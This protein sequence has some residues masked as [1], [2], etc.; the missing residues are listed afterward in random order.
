MKKF[1]L[2][3]ILFSL[4]LCSC[5]TKKEYTK[6]AVT[7]EFP[8]EVFIAD[9]QIPVIEHLQNITIIDSVKII[10]AEK[11]AE[12]IGSSADLY[13]GHNFVGL[14]ALKYEI[15][16]IPVSVEIAQFATNEDAYGFY[17]L[18]RPN[19]GQ[20]NRLGGESYTAG[21][22]TY[23]YIANFAVSLSVE[24][25][26]DDS[27]EIVK[28]LADAIVKK[29]ETQPTLPPYFLMFPFK[30]KISPSN[31][32]YPYNYLGII[33]LN[34][35]FTSDYII[36]GDTVTLF[37]A[38]DESGAKF[39]AIKEFAEATDDEIIDN[40]KGFQFESNISFAFGHPDHGVIVSGLTHNKIA[41]VI[42]YNPKKV[43]RFVTGWIKGLQ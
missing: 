42:N 6:T 18:L 36:D 9:L 35:V 33:D 1:I 10:M 2:T 24:G 3:T 20:F 16:K 23:F 28:P 38:M 12:F 30:N 39:Y 29:T 17:S 15:S 14:V 5:S 11:A 25:E 21:N 32:Y 31:R 13:R 40:P 34:G 22:S 27:F 41:G 37:Y 7:P 19:T 43:G 8:S 26:T 4:V